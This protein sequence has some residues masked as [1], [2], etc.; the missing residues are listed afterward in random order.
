MP[1]WGIFGCRCAC[2]PGSDYA[3]DQRVALVIGVTVLA[4]SSVKN[5]R[6]MSACCNLRIRTQA[7]KTTVRSRRI[8]EGTLAHCSSQPLDVAIQA[9]IRPI[10]GDLTADARVHGLQLG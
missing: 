2:K 10:E 9:V 5:R 7:R 6:T 3:A 8:G 4:D 1:D